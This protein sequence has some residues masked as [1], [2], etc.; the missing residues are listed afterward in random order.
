MK[1]AHYFYQDP[2]AFEKEYTAAVAPEIVPT[3]AR[4]KKPKKGED[5]EDEDFTTVTKGGKG[6]TFSPENIFKNLQVVQENRGKKV[7]IHTNY[8]LLPL[9]HV[10]CPEH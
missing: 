6:I 2:E 9:A 3:P 10:P 8:R 1:C 4:V 5:E 7:R